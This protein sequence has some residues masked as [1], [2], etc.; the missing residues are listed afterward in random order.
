M[1]NKKQKTVGINNP[2]LAYILSWLRRNDMY[3]KLNKDLGLEIEPD[4]G[5]IDSSTLQQ[6]L[7]K[8]NS[9]S[10]HSW[11][12]CIASYCKCGNYVEY[13]KQHM[14][15]YLWLRKNNLLYEFQKTIKYSKSKS[16][17]IASKKRGR[18]IITYDMCLKDWNDGRFKYKSDYYRCYSGNLKYL[19]RKKLLDKFLDEVLTKT[20]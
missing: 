10:I 6:K 3:E 1:K 15:Q 14:N 12:S 2:E 5:N 17:V 8:L 20:N 11:E 19:Q 7:K 9:S 18:N 4:D 13:R 16:I